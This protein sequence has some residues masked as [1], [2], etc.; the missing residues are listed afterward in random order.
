MVDQDVRTEPSDGWRHPREHRDETRGRILDAALQLIAER[1]FAGTST[2]EISER[3]GFTKAALYYHFRTK[4]DLL[5]AIV[6]P[7]MDEL[8][9]LVGQGA[10]TCSPA[11]RRHVLERY[12]DL[13]AGHAALIKVLSDD[14]SVRRSDVLGAALP[15]FQRL[16]QV[17]AGSDH[18]NVAERALARAA[19]GAVHATLVRADPGDDPATLRDVAVRVA[20]VVLGLAGSRS[21]TARP[22]GRR[23]GETAP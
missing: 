9:A 21:A 17:L 23:G 6:K 12:V 7:A 8:V 19:L 10:G 2:R 16:V 15:Q 22:P 20:L 11:E 18:P 3:L 1:G 5:A 13:V 14:P 4:A